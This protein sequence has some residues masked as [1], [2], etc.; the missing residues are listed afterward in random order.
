MTLESASL[1]IAQ[2][3]SM[4]V[5]CI[6]TSDTAK[7]DAEVLLA[8][9][10]ERQRSYLYTWPERLL[11]ETQAERYRSLL[12]QRAQGVPIAHL[13]GEREFWSLPLQVNSSTLIPRPDTEVLVEQALAL[14]LP[15]RSKVLDLGTGTGAI[16][17]ALKQSRPHWQITAVDKI[18]AAVDLARQNAQA[19]TLDIRCF[20]SDWFSAVNPQQRFDVIISNPPYIDAKDLHLEQGDLRY[21][22]R[23]ALVAAANGMADIHQ[24]VNAASSYLA[25]AGWLLLEH[26]CAQGAA[27]REQLQQAGFEQVTTVRDYANLERVTL[28]QWRADHGE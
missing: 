23:S 11:T 26:G 7:L 13:V 3:L 27:V 24:I 16:A 15:Q 21:E 9:C 19:L 8:F 10:L 1:S 4:G 17:L 28:G 14:D 12:L 25:T 6:T 18:A 20:Q 2:A 5:E 22:P